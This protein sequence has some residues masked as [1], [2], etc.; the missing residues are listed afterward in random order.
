MRLGMPVI[1]SISQN[2]RI[3][4]GAAPPLC[5]PAGAYFDVRHSHAGRGCGESR[6]GHCVLAG[7][8]VA[9]CGGLEKIRR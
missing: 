2:G 1:C 9:K 4:R 6:I 5:S 8:R 3:N 7:Q